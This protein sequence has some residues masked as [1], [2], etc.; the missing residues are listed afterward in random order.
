MT[1]IM[2]IITDAFEKRVKEKGQEAYDQA[3]RDG[4]TAEQAEA[5]RQE[6]ELWVR[7]H[8]GPLW[9]KAEAQARETERIQKALHERGRHLYCPDKKPD[10]SV[11]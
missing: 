6:T 8:D 9:A 4:M 7:E 3:L 5:L 1:S 11:H 10:D 2:S